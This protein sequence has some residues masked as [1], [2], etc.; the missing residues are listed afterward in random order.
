VF[1][2]LLE[3]L[4]SWL[5]RSKPQPPITEPARSKTRWIDLPSSEEAAMWR[6]PSNRA[7]LDHL[8]EDDKQ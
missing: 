4:P 2:A 3:A 8:P 7:Y 5:K 1:Q 6:H